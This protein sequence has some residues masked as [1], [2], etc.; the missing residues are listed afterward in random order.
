MIPEPDR[1]ESR[2]QKESGPTV[3]IDEDEDTLRAAI[4]RLLQ[5]EGYTVLETQVR[6]RLPIVFRPNPPFSPSRSG[7]T[8]SLPSGGSSS[9]HFEVSDLPIGQQDTL[10][11]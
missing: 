9:Q 1:D 2:L 8:T 4:R 5:D 10:R 3:L 6:P 7:M 11:W